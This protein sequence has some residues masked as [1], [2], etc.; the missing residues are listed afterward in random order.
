MSQAGIDGIPD[1]TVRVVTRTELEYLSDRL[2]GTAISSILTIG[3]RERED[4]ILASR[5][6]RRLL[7]AFEQGAGRQLHTLLINGGAQ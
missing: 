1:C 3:P 7:G 2:Y 5:A 6:I 4:M